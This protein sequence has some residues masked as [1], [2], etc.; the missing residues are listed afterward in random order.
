M[1]C[2]DSDPNRRRGSFRFSLRTLFLVV[3]GLSAACGIVRVFPMTIALLTVA[4]AA[5]S[6]W[7]AHCRK[8]AAG[9]SPH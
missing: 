9:R 7:L 8:A 4:P 5:L 1:A 6:S 3:M 2:M